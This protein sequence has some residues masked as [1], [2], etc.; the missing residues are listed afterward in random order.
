[1]VYK[2]RTRE[3]LLTLLRPEP[4]ASSMTRRESN[5]YRKNHCLDSMHTPIV[6]SRAA[7]G[8]QFAGPRGGPARTPHYPNVDQ[9][10]IFEMTK[11]TFIPKK[12][13]GPIGGRG[14]MPIPPT[15]TEGFF[16]AG[17]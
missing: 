6:A 1:M 15:A 14:S 12:I 4:Q 7:R 11:H 9:Q 2:S 10:F 13:N 8:M 17:S 5:P 16:H 3:T